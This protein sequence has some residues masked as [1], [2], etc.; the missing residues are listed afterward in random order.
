MVLSLLHERTTIPAIYK[1][2]TK[3]LYVISQ[4]QESFIPFFFL[5]QQTALNTTLITQL[6]TTRWSGP[7][8]WNHCSISP[9]QRNLNM[10]F[11]FFLLFCFFAFCC[12]CCCFVSVFSCNIS[13]FW[14]HLQTL[15]RKYSLKTVHKQPEQEGK[16]L[17]FSPPPLENS[18]KLWRNWEKLPAAAITELSLNKTA[19]GSFCIVIHA[20]DWSESWP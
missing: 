12:C 9:A 10:P 1:L 4:Y 3:V 20:S 13:V 16:L 14:G 19:T 7:Q 15:F 18:D 2:R 17:S 8:L 5:N 11:L 6:S